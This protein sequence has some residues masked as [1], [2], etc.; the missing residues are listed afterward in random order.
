MVKR[1]KQGRMYTEADPV[2]VDLEKAR[3]E[4]RD[5]IQGNV[6]FHVDPF[7]PR[8][9]ADI[10]LDFGGVCYCAYVGGLCDSCSDA[11]Y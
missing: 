9:Q 5:V 10:P 1:D 11:R 7:T 8:P 3:R 6:P 4:C 2:P